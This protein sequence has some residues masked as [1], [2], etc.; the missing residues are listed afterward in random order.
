MRQRTYNLKR[1]LAVLLTFCIA[2]CTMPYTVSAKY[3]KSMLKKDDITVLDYF[4]CK[5]TPVEHLSK[6]EN[7]KYYLTTRSGGYNGNDP[8]C[9][10]PNGPD[11]KGGRMNCTGFVMAVIRG[12]GGTIPFTRYTSGFNVFHHLENAG[13]KHYIFQTIGKAKA[14]G[15]MEK[16]DYVWYRPVGGGDD[17]WAIYWGKGLQWENARGCNR[18]SPM[19]GGSRR[20]IVYIFKAQPHYGK[21]KLKVTP[22]V[23]KTKTAGGYS[24]KGITFKVYKKDKKTKVATVKTNAK[25]ATKA[26]E[27]PEGTYYYKE[28]STGKTGYKRFKKFHK[29]VVKRNETCTCKLKNGN[30]Y[31]KLNVTVQ[32]ETAPEDSVSLK[33]FHITIKNVKNGKRYSAVTNKKGVAV[34][35][36]VL[37]GTYTVSESLTD[38][39]KANGIRVI[40]KKHRVKIKVKKTHKDTV[41][42]EKDPPAEE[43]TEPSEPSEQNE[44]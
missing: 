19:H 28:T 33:G 29:A 31:G 43:Q 34:F 35:D 41:I 16:G 17:H 39:Q 24:L 21:L 5:I 26:I 13:V 6:H 30:Y 18:I 36:K 25:G 37:A 15:V 4:K 10:T 8:Y 14:S 1:L 22:K 2:A 44:P 12:C 38:E 3:E 11:G 27:L 9:S 40:T 7:D 42:N 20:F 32:I 23:T